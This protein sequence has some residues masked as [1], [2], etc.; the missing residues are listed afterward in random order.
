MTLPMASKAIV[1]ATL[2]ASTDA[3]KTLS[4]R[5]FSKMGLAREYLGPFRC[6]MKSIPA[7]AEHLRLNVVKFKN[8]IH[9]F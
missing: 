4:A 2:I 6:E 8:R 9:I 1:T 3:Q 5:V 7:R